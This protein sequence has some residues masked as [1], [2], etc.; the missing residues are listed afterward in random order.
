[1]SA[2]T[3]EITQQWQRGRERL[4]LPESADSLLE[5]LHL[6]FVEALQRWHQARGS[7]IV[8]GLQGCQGAGKS[9]LCDLVP[10]LAHQLFGLRIAV[11]ALDDVYL[12]RSERQQLARSEHPLWITRGVPGTHES[13]LACDI[14]QRLARGDEKTVRVPVFDKGTD[15]RLDTEQQLQGPYDVVIFEGWCV[16]LGSCADLDWQTAINPLE[17]QEDA[18]MTW[19]NRI[20]QQLAGPYQQL[21]SLFD[22]LAI[23]LVPSWETVSL[24]RG[25]Q[26]QKL[27]LDRGDDASHSMDDAALRRFLDHYERLTRW[28]IETLPSRADFVARIAPDRSVLGIETKQENR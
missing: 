1:M 3:P 13:P 16:G 28:T 23:L 19:R 14:L 20:R 24:W 27:R 18:Q 17:E 5:H 7:T 22:H 15:D 10:D 11:V 4:G 12:G 9:T 6:P 21:F 8:V 26:E 25:Q 2:I